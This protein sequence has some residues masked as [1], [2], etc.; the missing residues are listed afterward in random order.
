MPRG[1]PS[2]RRAC[3]SVLAGLTA[4]AAG[5]QNLNLQDLEFTGIT[6]CRLIDTRNGSGASSSDDGPVGARSSPGPYDI[7]IKGFCGV[8]ANARA[9][10]LNLTVVAP[11]QAGDLRIA[12]LDADPFPGVST[13]NYAAGVGA[14]ANAAIV[15]LKLGPGNDV[16][17][18]FAMVAPGTLHILVDVSGYFAPPGTGPLWGRGRPGAKRHTLPGDFICTQGPYNFGLS[19]IA[20]EWGAA[21]DACPQGTWVCTAA[22]RGTQVC[23]TDRPDS[24]CD[25]RNCAGGCLDSPANQHPGWLADQ[26]PE[27]FFGNLVGACSFEGGGDP[28]DL[29]ACE[30]L[31]VWCCSLN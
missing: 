24:T 3:L 31:P 9:V 15:P 26:I 10:T 11:T 29:I 25:G 19:A 21:A 1:S 6:P 20:V 28:L 5:G 23:N 4:T 2:L 13:V 14:L 17:M 7:A 18:L 16:R 22:Q 30:L 8:P 12:P 27:D